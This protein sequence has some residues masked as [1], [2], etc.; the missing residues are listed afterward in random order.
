MTEILHSKC[1]NFTIPLLFLSL[2]LLFQDDDERRE[3]R[4]GRGAVDGGGA[5]PQGVCAQAHRGVRVRAAATGARGQGAV[6]G[7][8]RALAGQPVAQP[9]AAAA[10]PGQAEAAPRALRQV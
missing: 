6:P 10:Q 3:Q 8:G 1:F 7:R 2:P 9:D 4:A 5:L